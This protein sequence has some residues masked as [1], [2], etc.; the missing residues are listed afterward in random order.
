MI[1]YVQAVMTAIGGHTGPIV[2]VVKGEVS[3]VGH[4][5][6]HARGIHEMSKLLP[7][8]F[9]NGMRSMAQSQERLPL[10]Q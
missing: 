8:L 1:K 7:G 3:Y 2:A 4:G 10:F 5:A 9:P 6:A